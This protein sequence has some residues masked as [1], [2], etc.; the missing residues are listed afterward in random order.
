VIGRRPMACFA[1]AFP[2]AFGCGIYT[3]ETLN[4]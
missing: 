1:G 2:G 4:T 3:G